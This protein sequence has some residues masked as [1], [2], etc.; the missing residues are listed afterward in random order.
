MKLYKYRSLRKFDFVADILCKQRFHASS[1]FDLNDPM[2]GLFE[3][4]ESTKQ[5]YI[6]AIVEGKRKLRICAFSKDCN[7]IL[8]W[9]HYADGFKG[10]CIELD[11]RETQLE[12]MEGYEIVTAKYS[13][14]RV[15]FSNNARHIVDEMPRIILSKK[16]SVWKYEKEVRTLSRDEYIHDGVSIKSVLLGLRTHEILKEA[17]FRITPPDIPIFET[18]ISNSNKIEKGQRFAPVYRV[19]RGR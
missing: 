12:D 6:D 13:S 2:E 18:Y 7:N 1:F 9:A 14:Q 19:E 10:I 5:E 15:S 16:S 11:L 8:L 3:Y 4:P 17:I